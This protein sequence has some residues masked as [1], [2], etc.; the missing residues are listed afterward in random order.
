MDWLVTCALPD[1]GPAHRAA[2][3]ALPVT[4]LPAG[5]TLFRPGDRA[6]GFLVL[7]EGR[8]EVFLTG[9]SGREILLYAVEPGQSCIQTTLG[10]M[11]D[12]VYAG[13]AVTAG[14][15]RAVTIPRA[16]FLRLMDEAPAF[17]AF[18]FRAFG[19]R[20]AEM[21][22]LLEQVAFHSVE[23]RLARALLTLAR[24]QAV[25]A[26]QAEIAS[27]IGSAREVVSRKL[28]ALAAR[29]LIET[30]RGRVRLIDPAGLRRL[31]DVT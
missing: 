27:Q 5:T 21:T 19:A 7:T 4:A 8:V 6:G 1:P 28:D 11:G 18:V 13:E 24:D 2:L 14:P 9:P 25:T 22:R 20:M 15:C 3:A 12:E 10:L 30:E 17:R 26:T 23:R 31:A 29:G 16:L